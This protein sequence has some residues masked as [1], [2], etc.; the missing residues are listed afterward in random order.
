MPQRV[1]PMVRP[2]LHAGGGVGDPNGNSGAPGLPPG[3]TSGAKFADDEARELYA[4]ARGRFVER[5]FVFPDFAIF[6]EATGP[7]TDTQQIEVKSNGDSFVRLVAMRGV[8]NTFGSFGAGN[9]FEAKNTFLQLQADG[10]EDFTTSGKTVLPISFDAAF[11]ENAAPWLW[12][13][14]PPL[15]R[16]GETLAATITVKQAQIPSEVGWQPQLALRL[17]DDAVWCQLYG[18]SYA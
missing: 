9:N 4:L 8:V 5:L 15:L 11:S 2:P 3:G 1:I 6:E 18:S 10:L 13:A 12:L 14:A 16:V 7:A 17:V